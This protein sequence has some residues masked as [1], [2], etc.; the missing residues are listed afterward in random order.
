MKVASF[1]VH[2][3]AQQSARW[4]Q[5]AEHEGHRSAGSWLAVAADRYLDGLRR[6]GR[7]VPLAWHRGNFRVTLR[8]GETIT[9][10]GQLSPPFGLFPGTP[11]GPASY[12][13]RRRFTLVFVPQDRILATLRTAAHCRALASE[14]S[15]VWVRWGG[16]EPIEDPAPLL[17]RFQREDL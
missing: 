4:K 7:P 12:Q 16:S 3:T 8:G 11:E 6:A 17:Q 2:A 15:R 9:V 5:A 13:G 14:L 1:T 10:K